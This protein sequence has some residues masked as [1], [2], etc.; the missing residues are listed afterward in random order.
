MKILNFG[1]CNID[2]VYSLNHIV[3]AG[4]TAVSLNMNTFPGGKGLNQSIAL[5]RAG[6]KAYHAG[7][8]G[9]DGE[10]LLNLLK[11]NGVDI[12]N[13]MRVNSK[14]GHAII[15][16]SCDG[17]NSI[18]IYPGSNA[19]VTDKYIQSVLQ[20]FGKGDFILLQN[21]INMVDSIIKKAYEK[22][23]FI[24]LNPSPCNEKIMN[25]DLNMV[26]YLILNEIEAKMLTGYTL[27]ESSLKYFVEKYPNIKV[28]LTLGKKGSI[29]CD[30]SN[31]I[32]Q[33]SF[34]VTTVDTTAA[35][36]TFTGYFIA[37]TARGEN[38]R[39]ALKIASAAAAISVSK[40]GAAPS[41]PKLCEVLTAVNLM[42]ENADG[43]SKLTKDK[44]NEYA[45]K[46]LKSASIEGLAKILGYSESYTQSIVKNLFGAPFS[47]LIQSKRCD[48]AAQMLEETDLPV[49]EIIN[50]TGYENENFFRKIFKQK[51]GKN[52]LEYR[53]FIRR[54]K[55]E[56]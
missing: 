48:A 18:F 32:F 21:E 1:S 52:M 20:N 3:A 54:T 29:Y 19:M 46:N 56:H 24:V 41:I 27:P 17:E 50:K 42:S 36:D 10:L 35:G 22:E 4:E 25:I 30:K 33:P 40:N 13:I 6:I 37:M 5:A 38:Y 23:I 15:Q 12:S 9:N 44:I 43:K 16:V 14:N 53:K 51:Y 2:F 47:K 8:I 39:K 28:V 55:N 26:S 31:K 34:C 45:K 49:G 11:D 7:C